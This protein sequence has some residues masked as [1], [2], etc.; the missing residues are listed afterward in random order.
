MIENLIIL[1]LL[2][3]ANGLITAIS[4][5][6]RTV[7]LKKARFISDSEDKNTDKLKHILDKAKAHINVAGFVES[8]LI[9][10]TGYIIMGNLSDEVMEMISAETLLGSETLLKYAV[11][12]ILICITTYA[13]TF[14]GNVVPKIIATKYPDKVLI[15]CDWILS[16]LYLIFSPL[17]ALIN[18]SA[19]LVEKLFKLNKDDVEDVSE[20]EILMMIDA[21]EEVGNIDEDEKEMINNIFEFD[22]KIAGEISTHRK[23]IVSI[24]IKS[25]LEEIIEVVTGEKYTRIPVYEE[26]IDNIIGILHVKDFMKN[27]IINGKGGFNVSDILM[28]PFFVPFTKKTD[29]LFKEMQAN[30]VHMAIVV[31]E[32]GGTAGIVTMEDLIEEVMGNILD[33]Y[34]E[35]EEPEI[36]VLENN[37]WV[38]DGTTSLDDVAEIL[39][40]EFPLDEYETLSGFI[41]GQLGRIPEDNEDISIIY[42]QLLFRVEKIEDKRIVSVRVNKYNKDENDDVLLTTEE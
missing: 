4:S 35:E 12:I 8:L 15:S 29:D 38:I 24:D 33:E 16:L 34:D 7:E 32:Y 1:V 21:G 2:I 30:K 20:E 23:D 41:I 19:V 31:D 10:V 9:I 3:L 40:T 42:G 17:V 26:N 37:T 39:D 11:I 22:D 28:T 5:S 27:I 14:F 13:L 36:A 18:I 25:T 6:I